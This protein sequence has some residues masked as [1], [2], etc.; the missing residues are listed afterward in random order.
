[1][2]GKILWETWSLVV[3][4]HYIFCRIKS[5]GLCRLQMTHFICDSFIC[6]ANKAVV[7]S[8]SISLDLCCTRLYFL[9]DNFVYHSALSR[10]LLYLS[11]PGRAHILVAPIGI[12]HISVDQAAT[13]EVP[14]RGGLDRPKQHIYRTSRNNYSESL[15]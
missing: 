4:C 6:Y 12:E 10:G 11:R 1:M 14:V 13:N 15:I 3:P 7:F 2:N 5:L 8:F 9:F